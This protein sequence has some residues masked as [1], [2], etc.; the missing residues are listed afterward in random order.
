MAKSKSVIHGQSII[1]NSEFI[2]YHLAH[3][4]Y[5]DSLKLKEN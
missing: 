4:C 2:I 3:T 5:T 1:A